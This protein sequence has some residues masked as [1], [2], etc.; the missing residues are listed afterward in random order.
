MTTCTFLYKVILNFSE[1]VWE[2]MAAMSVK[3]RRLD[4]AALCLGHMGLA[5]GARGLNLLFNYLTILLCVTV[6]S[7]ASRTET[8]TSS[9]SSMRYVGCSIRNAGKSIFTMLATI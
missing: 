5:R 3:T 2:H 8:R 7:S 9:R 6:S 4:V 1:S